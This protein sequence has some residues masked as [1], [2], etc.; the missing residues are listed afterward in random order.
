MPNIAAVLIQAIKIAVFFATLALP[1]DA[2]AGFSQS[3]PPPIAAIHAA[4]RP[5]SNPRRR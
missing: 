4:D 2:G 3:P 1:H 5:H